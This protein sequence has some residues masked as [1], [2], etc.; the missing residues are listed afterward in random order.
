MKEVYDKFFEICSKE[1]QLMIQEFKQ[2]VK[3]LNENELSN[4]Y[5]F[6]YSIP[7]YPERILKD[8]FFSISLSENYILFTM[9]DDF[10][11]EYNFSTTFSY[12][13]KEDSYGLDFNIFNKLETDNDRFT[14][15]LLKTKNELSIIDVNNTIKIEINS[16]SSKV[17]EYGYDED[18]YVFNDDNIINLV[19]DNYLSPLELNDLLLLNEDINVIEDKILSSIISQATTLYNHKNNVPTIKL[20]QQH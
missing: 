17:D 10:N 19:L 3:I 13:I 4:K 5:H 1:N 2:D 14:I 12:S 16:K 15:F 8:S 6:D 9:T 20:K 11:Q 7:R 18:F